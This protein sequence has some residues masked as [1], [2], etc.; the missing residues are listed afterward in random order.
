MTVNELSLPVATDIRPDVTLAQL[1]DDPYPVYTWMRRECPVAYVPD[2]HLVLLTTWA[3]CEEAGRDRDHLMPGQEPFNTAYGQPNILSLAGEAHASL[4]SAVNPPF[5]PKPIKA[6]R[7]ELF[8]RVARAHIATLQ[9][10]GRADIAEDLLEPISL[11]VVAELLGLQDVAPETRKRWFNGFGAYLVDRGRDPQVAAT[12]EALKVELREYLAQRVAAM[13]PESD[14]T[15]LWH[16]FHD[17]MPAGEL[18]E[19]DEVIATV[20]VLIVGGFQEPAHAIAATLLGVLPSADFR[21][22]LAADP[23]RWGPP[24]FEEAL[25]WLP[26]F[27]VVERDVVS[28][29]VIGG[30]LIPAGSSV[31]LV[32]GAA[33]RDPERWERPDEYDL[34]RTAQNHMAFGYGDH[35]C[36]GHLAARG[37]AQVVLEEL[38][39][40][41]PGLRLDLERPPVVHGWKARGPKSLPV[42][43]DV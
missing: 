35:F 34:D 2:T 31:G 16:L 19:I 32:M 25:R 5:R 4:R 18:R 10:S 11:E 30:V 26:P 13:P 8:R 42:V 40:G 28:D 43:W 41:L 29:M 38:F 12:G 3:L 9:A 1:E 17:G 23:E 20:A 37:L 6:R 22:R 27:G 15:A 14:H 21:Q 36:V 33:N 24:A 7:D 39:R